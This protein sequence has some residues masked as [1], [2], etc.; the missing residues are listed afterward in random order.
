MTCLFRIKSIKRSSGG[1]VGI[2]N[3]RGA[4]SLKTFITWRRKK[5]KKCFSTGIC[6]AKVTFRVNKTRSH[7]HRAAGAA[8]TSLLVHTKS[9]KTVCLQVLWPRSP[10][11]SRSPRK[12]SCGMPCWRRPPCTRIRR[13][14]CRLQDRGNREEVTIMKYHEVLGEIPRPSPPGSQNLLW[15]LKK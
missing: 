3:S 8:L 6:V 15:R 12:L 13:T 1:N 2:W 5:S 4:A 14:G 11:C 7:H 9:I 10:L